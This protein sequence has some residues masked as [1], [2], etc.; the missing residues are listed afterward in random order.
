MPKNKKFIIGMIVLVAALALTVWAF[1]MD[2]LKSHQYWLLRALIPMSAGFIA[3]SFH[4]VLNLRITNSAWEGASI[5]AMGGFAAFVIMLNVLTPPKIECHVTESAEQRTKREFRELRT[6]VLELVADYNNLRQR[7]D[8]LDDVRNKAKILGEKLN[9]LVPSNLNIAEQIGVRLNSATA[10]G[11]SALAEDAINVGTN[12][13]RSEFILPCV[14]QV[15]AQAKSALDRLD[16]FNHLSEQ[17]GV[18]PEEFK[19]E[20][21]EWLQADKVR[22]Y[23]LLSLAQAQAFNYKYRSTPVEEVRVALDRLDRTYKD[24]ANLRGD[25]IFSEVCKQFPE[26]VCGRDGETAKQAKSGES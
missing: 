25:P 16:D 14:D 13:T 26:P 10:Y 2:C 19:N 11:I 9:R 17:P 1:S 20:T 3:W 23:L 7:R 5:G 18:L 22:D 15:F 8:L 6:H 21:L 24:R 12:A 4:G